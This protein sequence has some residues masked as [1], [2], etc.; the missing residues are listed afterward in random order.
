MSEKIA[1]IGTGY[2]GLTTGACMAALGHDV[3]CIDVVAEK[4]QSLKAGNVPIHEPGLD[5]LV[6]EGIAAGRLRFELGSSGYVE[7]RQFLFL[8]VP[9]PQGA[10]GAADLRYVQEAARE[11]SQL[12]R[13][14][15]IVINKSTVPVGSAQMVAEALG[16]SD[17]FVVSN[18]EFLREGTAVRDFNEPDRVVVGAD[19]REAA[20]RVAA[21]YAGLQA[22]VHITDPASA[23][24]IK[25]ASNAFLA[26]KLSFVNDI[27]AVCDAVG[28]DVRE[29]MRGMG[30]D[31]RIGAE[32]LH[33]GPGWGGSC[34]PKDTVAL[35]SIA[36]EYDFDFAL[37]DSVVRSNKA[38]FVRMAD[39]VRRAVGGA[40]DGKRVAVLGLTFKANTDDL[41]DSPALE[42]IDLL[43]ADGALIRA[44]DPL[45]KTLDRPGVDVAESPY[46]AAIDA[47]V[48][49]ILTE[50]PEFAALDLVRLGDDMAARRIVD[51]RN[52]LDSKTVQDAGF[53]YEGVGRR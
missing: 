35:I 22:E 50:W 47:E 53:T 39:K 31:R 48:L 27:A 24:T 9:T 2:V 41:R 5:K 49:V 20:A 19:D 51:T 25:Y 21:L 36:K 7:D 16:R 23:E 30:M 37:L 11:L 32:F 38:Q 29:V 33:P 28:A 8:C 4:V 45:V 34:F 13:P 14:G 44:F 43:V 15:A 26:T 52:L 42:V 6:A 12:I 10:D 18:P 40:L 46:A 1:V 17:V 3:V